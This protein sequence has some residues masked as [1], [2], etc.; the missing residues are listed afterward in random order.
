MSR[1]EQMKDEFK[2]EYKNSPQNQDLCSDLSGYAQ[3]QH[4][5]RQKANV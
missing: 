3:H 1:H 5:E 2:F 4:I